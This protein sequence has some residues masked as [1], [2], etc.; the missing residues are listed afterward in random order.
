MIAISESWKKKKKKNPGT[1]SIKFIDSSH[2]EEIWP[3]G[4]RFGHKFLANL[5]QCE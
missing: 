5:T 4:V 1:H 3:G 2:K